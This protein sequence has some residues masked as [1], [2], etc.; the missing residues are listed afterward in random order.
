MGSLTKGSTDLLAKVPGRRRGRAER[1]QMKGRRTV[2]RAKGNDALR[3]V[4]SRASGAWERARSLSKTAAEGIARR[5]GR[6][7]GRRRA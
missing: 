6:S 7:R 4:G 3:A 2:E 5:S 1:V